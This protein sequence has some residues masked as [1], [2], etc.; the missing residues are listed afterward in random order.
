MNFTLQRVSIICHESL[1][2]MRDLRIAC[3]RERTG[4]LK[5]NTMPRTSG[6]GTFHWC[7][8]EKSKISIGR[9]IQIARKSNNLLLLIIYLQL[10]A[11]KN[12]IK[13]LVSKLFFRLLHDSRRTYF[14]RPTEI[15]LCRAHA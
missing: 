3:K 9:V 7:D 12:E 1:K 5:T 14:H 10:K 11:I 2:N 6:Y 8:F 13:I 15:Y 4:R